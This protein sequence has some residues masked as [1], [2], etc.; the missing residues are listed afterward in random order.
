MQRQGDRQG[1]SPLCPW[2]LPFLMVTGRLRVS[3]SPGVH[4]LLEGTCWGLGLQ[5]GRMFTF[6]QLARWDWSVQ[7]SH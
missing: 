5:E 6:E 4:L 1:A 3:E 7:A 2:P